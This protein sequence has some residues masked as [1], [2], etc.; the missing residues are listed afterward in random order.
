MTAVLKMNFEQLKDAQVKI[1]GKNI[2]GVTF[3][4]LSEDNIHEFAM[5]VE[6]A[7]YDLHFSKTAVKR[8][9]LVVIEG[10]QNILRHGHNEGGSDIEGGCLV[11]ESESGIEIYCMNQVRS[12][13][14]DR[15]IEMIAQFNNLEV[16]EL[17]SRYLEELSTG[18][19][20]QKNGAGLGLMTIRLKSGKPLKCYFYNIDEE[21]Q[22][23]AMVSSIDRDYQ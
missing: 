18:E 5:V 11:V 6:K 3:G 19:I 15:L 14:K 12:T 2:I 20:S 22:G 7:L 21:W 17:K 8:C 13:E 23:F 1:H 16:E 10:L 4:P 9:F